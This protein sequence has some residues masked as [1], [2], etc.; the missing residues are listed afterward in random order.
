MSFFYIRAWIDGSTIV[1]L[2]TGEGQITDAGNYG[3]ATI[4]DAVGEGSFI[5]AG[6]LLPTLSFD[7]NGL[8][9]SLTT[10]YAAKDVTSL[11]ANSGYSGKAVYNW[12][13]DNL[14]QWNGDP[15]G[16]AAITGVSI[17]AIADDS[18][19]VNI[20]AESIP[21][22]PTSLQ[23][24]GG[25]GQIVLSWAPVTTNTDTSAL[26]DFLH[27]NI[28]RNTTDNFATATLIASS[29]GQT[30]ID[31]GLGYEESYYY[32][33]TA[34]DLSGNEGT[35]SNS[36]TATTNLI[37][38][39][40]MVADIRAEIQ[41]ANIRVL[42][43]LTDGSEAEVGDMIFLQADQKLYQW[44]GTSWTPVVGEIPG[45]TIVATM[46]TD[47][48]VTSPKIIANA[49]TADKIDANA[50][51]ADKI[52]ANAI[53]SGKIEAGAVSAD[54]IAVNTLAAINANL[55][56]VIAGS[57]NTVNNSVGLQVNI[58]SRP[59]AV[60]IFQN[61]ELIYGLYVENVYAPPGTTAAG[62]A[63]KIRSN[64]GYG[65]EID[66]YGDYSG[67]QAA[68][69][70]Q[71]SQDL[72]AGA[73]P[74]FPGG[75]VY[76]ARG[77]TES[78][79][80]VEVLRGGYYDTSGDGYLP[81]TGAHEALLPKTETP[82]IGDILCDVRAVVTGISN[83]LTEVNVSNGP[84]QAS[85]VGVF[86][87]YKTSWESVAAFV[88]RGKTNANLARCPS[89][90]TDMPTGCVRELCVDP[91][92]FKS[93]FNLLVMNSL[94]EGGINVCGEG[95]DIQPGD[96]I[97]TSSIPGKGMKQAD[98]IVRSYTV[99]KARDAVS[100]TSPDEIKMIACIY[101]CG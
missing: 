88:D 61:E 5:D 78:G 82:C 89:E 95:G 17:R 32:W 47:D 8:A 11:F 50:V 44:D 14:Y 64:S 38:A 3:D 45:D 68:A 34:V 21:S 101:L 59:N 4:V 85:A 97:V 39:A 57:I 99:A 94:G 80:G 75:A 19:N 20:G 25:A 93:S 83:S 33:V 76:L 1:A 10:I 35:Q 2:Q 49:I 13:D 9:S 26:T 77:A 16:S 24:I 41:A 91:E 6:T 72:G 73:S 56:A 52:I 43:A 70:I 15:W 27:Y 81:F 87:D 69:F 54:K 84:R 31:G 79:Y 60:Y 36:A 18:F 46:I 86:K 66:Q 62:G 7:L 30:Y 42:A 92:Q 48:A 37:S 40:D 98:D 65:L 22:P 90:S 51:T 100:F 12:T 63:A 55:G 74:R 71:N 96:L 53:T 58:T 28:Y 29:A 67:E 23:A